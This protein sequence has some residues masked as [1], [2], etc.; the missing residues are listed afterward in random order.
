MLQIATGMNSDWPRS[1]L[2]TGNVQYSL[3]CT[4][5][6]TS[7][8]TIAGHYSTSKPFSVANATENTKIVLGPPFSA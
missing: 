8:A 5:V 3:H 1:E 7:R 4:S 6:W 2:N